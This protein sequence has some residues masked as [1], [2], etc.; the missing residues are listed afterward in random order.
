MQSSIRLILRRIEE[1]AVGWG[2]PER[3]DLKGRAITTIKKKSA[4]K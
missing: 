1:E 2:V 4:Y 3:I